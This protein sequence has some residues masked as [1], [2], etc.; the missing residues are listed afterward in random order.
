MCVL[1]T[2]QHTRTSSSHSY[3][4]YISHTTNQIRTI[5]SVLCM[6]ARMQCKHVHTNT[7]T[8]SVCVCVCRLFS[9]GGEVED[10]QRA[11]KTEVDLFQSVALIVSDVSVP[12]P[13]RCRRCCCRFRSALVIIHFVLVAYLEPATELRC[14][15]FG[16]TLL[17]RNCKHTRDNIFR[18]PISVPDALT[19]PV[20][21]CKCTPIACVIHPK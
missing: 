4:W 13:R 7:Y 20:I 8:I 6:Y 14:W 17:N 9:L 10:Q 15:H 19:P 5:C 18:L 1:V 16:D 12:C 21:T 3:D 2:K 11:N